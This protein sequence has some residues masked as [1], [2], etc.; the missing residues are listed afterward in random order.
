MSKQSPAEYPR[1]FADAELRVVDGPNGKPRIVGYAA[2]F[3]TRSADLGGFYEEIAPGAFTEALAATNEVLA[4]VE[5]N[6]GQILGR[7]SAGTLTL[8]QDDHGLRF[9]I[10]PPET[11]VGNDAV[12]NV[13][14]KDISGGSFRFPRGAKD[15][16]RRDGGDSVRTIQK[17][18]LSEVTLTAIP[19]YDATSAS[20][21][22]SPQHDDE[23]RSYYQ[24]NIDALKPKPTKE[25]PV[26]TPNRNLAEKRLQLLTGEKRCCGDTIVV[27]EEDPSDRVRYVLYSCRSAFDSATIAMGKM[28]D[29]VE[30]P[31]A[32]YLRTCADAAAEANKTIARLTEFAAACRAAA[33]APP[34]T[35]DA[36]A[37][38]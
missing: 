24:K 25:T 23:L 27:I 38:A 32:D 7:R 8:T 2:V 1:Y 21:R 18:G 36:V 3:N 11:T 33:T 28:E 4:L 17:C 30:T 6:P 16:W 19:A 9:E 29:A 12:V 10:D 35:A 14:R 22:S 34:A 20:I 13:R 15:S 31:D 26:T 5:H 37:A